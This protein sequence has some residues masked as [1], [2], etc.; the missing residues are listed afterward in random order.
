MILI[1]LE[2]RE[3]ISFPPVGQSR[4]YKGLPRSCARPETSGDVHT[5]VRSLITDKEMGLAQSDHGKSWSRF[6]ALMEFGPYNLS[7]AKLIESHF[8]AITIMDEAHFTPEGF[9]DAEQRNRQFG[10]QRRLV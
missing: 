2:H 6:S 5:I 8:D 1:D 7:V 4:P 3:L 10:F 9:G